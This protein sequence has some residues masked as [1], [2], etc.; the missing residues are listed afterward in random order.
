MVKIWRKHTNK[1]KQFA[2]PP[3]GV[4]YQHC[5][6]YIPSSLFFCTY[7]FPFKSWNHFLHSFAN[8]L[9]LNS[10]LQTLRLIEYYYSKR[11]LSYSIQSYRYTVRLNNL[12]TKFFTV[13]NIVELNILV[14]ETF[15]SWDKFLKVKLV[16]QRAGKKS[17]LLQTCINCPPLRLSVY[18]PATICLFPHNLKNSGYD[19][20][21][22]PFSIW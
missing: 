1:I 10:T 16:G 18:T 14:T 4:Y 6:V 17:T 11:F 2:V 12:I 5:V 13:T 7:T 22:Q 9:T 21:F 8:F 19:H 3:L 20:V 15:Q